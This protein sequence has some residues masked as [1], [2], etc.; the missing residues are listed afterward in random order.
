MMIIIQEFAIQQQQERPENLRPEL[1]FEPQ[2][3][4][5]QRSAQPVELSDQLGRYVGRL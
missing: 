2:P 1:G 3:L 5:C 4:L